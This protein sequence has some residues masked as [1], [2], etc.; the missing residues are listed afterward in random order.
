[1]ADNP[2]AQFKKPNPFAVYKTQGTGP[3]APTGFAAPGTAQAVAPI[4]GG[5]Q[6]LNYISQ[7]EAA[8][9]AA[10][11][12]IQNRYEMQQIQAREAAQA[13]LQAKNNQ[14]PAGPNQKFDNVSGLRKELEGRN[15]VQVYKNALPSY[16]SALRSPDTPAG[17][18]DM[19]YAFAKIMDPNSVVREGEAASVADLGTMGQ[20]IVGDLRKQLDSKGKFTPELR[21]QLRNTLAGRVAEYDK[22]Y[23]TERGMYRG[24][25]QRNGMNPDDILGPHLGDAYAAIENQY[26]RGDPNKSAAAYRQELAAKAAAGGDTGGP[27]GPLPDAPLATG[28]TKAVTMDPKTAGLITAMIKNGYNADQMNAILVPTKM[29]GPEGFKQA[30]IEK[31]RKTLAAGGSLSP[32]Y[33]KPTSLLNR[34]AGTPVGVGIGAAGDAGAFGLSDEIAG[35]AD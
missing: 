35:M 10:A 24:I 5:P 1:M 29:I 27:N 14:L 30:D 18:Q 31:Y 26:F 2:F 32:Q 7:A 13:A 22:A 34:I 33:E 19:I 16:A 3:K 6:D 12:A 25:A 8:R 4:Q 23:N 9:V 11:Q 28:S 17:D 20:K 15:A 21:A